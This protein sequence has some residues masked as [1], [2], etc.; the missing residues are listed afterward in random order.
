M[1]A[2]P[3]GPYSPDGRY[4]WDGAAWQPVRN[5]PPA[6]A[7]QPG[8][9]H[10]Y[11]QSQ[12]GRPQP[13][14]MPQEG[15]PAGPPP[16]PYGQAPGTGGRGIGLVIGL[17]TAG[18]LLG[19]GVG[20]A[21]GL[22]SA[23]PKGSA[24]PPAFSADFP[25][26]DRRYLPGV[27]VAMI[28]DDWLKKSNKWKCAKKPDKDETSS[29]AAHRVECEP[30]DDRGDMSVYIEYDKEDSVRQVA[31]TCWLGLHTV[32]CTS[33]FS[34]MADTLLI[35]RKSLRKQAAGWA[36]KNADSERSTTIG[37]VRLEFDLSPHGMTATPGI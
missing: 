14:G 37:G 20:A 18:L 4:Q 5:P 26:G 12:P 21:A 25:G 9:P 19:G 1:T 30:P 16:G 35:P 28:S 33:L 23:S 22:G 24:R 31:A 6:A 7:P 11:G 10:S 8:P 15:T 36:K 13:Y 17:V 32:A 2:Q 3:P 34:T 29:G 27:T